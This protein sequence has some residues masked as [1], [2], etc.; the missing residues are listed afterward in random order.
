MT[1]ALPDGAS[2]LIVVM[3]LPKAELVKSFHLAIFRRIHPWNMDR[4]FTFIIAG[5]AANETTAY[6]ARIM[7][8]VVCTACT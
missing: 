2:P 3:A 1:S 4:P 6:P 7:E 5:N 8:D